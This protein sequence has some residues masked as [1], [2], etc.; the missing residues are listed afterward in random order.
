MAR[1]SDTSAVLGNEDQRRAAIVRKLA[2]ENKDLNIG[3]GT[4][5]DRA[6]PAASAFAQP[7]LASRANKDLNIGA[8]GS[9]P[10]QVQQD[11]LRQ[12][13]AA[14]AANERRNPGSTT[15][16]R[17]ADP[18]P[19][20][21]E[22]YG[23][24]NE[25]ALSQIAL[26]Q[27][28]AG[29]RAGSE[30]L[31]R[32]Q[33]ASE[34]SLRQLQGRSPLQRAVQSADQPSEQEA[35]ERG[36]LIGSALLPGPGILTKIPGVTPLLERAAAPITERA[37]PFLGSATKPIRE[38]IESRL[39][40]GGEDAFKNATRIGNENA[41]RLGESLPV[42]DLTKTRV[43][44]YLENARREAANLQRLQ[45]AERSLG[46]VDTPPTT[47][48]RQAILNRLGQLGSKVVQ[49]PGVRAVNPATAGIGL[50]A[51]GAA[52]LA[53][54]GGQASE[55]VPHGNAPEDQ[56]SLLP[57]GQTAPA[58][59][60]PSRVQLPQP[61]P[62]PITTTRPPTGQPLAVPRPTGP[63]TPGSQQQP[64]SQQQPLDQQ[65][66]LPPL[67][68]Q[69][70]PPPPSPG[71]LPPL[72]QLPF[73]QIP[74][75]AGPGV[76]LPQLSDLQQAIIGDLNG[77]VQ[78]INAG[79]Q[80]PDVMAL[81][82]SQAEKI[83]GLI[84][85]QEKQL[86]ADAANAGQSVDPATQNMIDQLKEALGEQ[87]KKTREAL[88]SRGLLNSGILIE[89]EQMLRKGNLSDQARIM[90]ERLSR[91][92][93]NL[94]A[95]LGTLRQQRVSTAQQYG[96]AGL[97]AQTQ[98]DQAERQRLQE[99]RGQVLQGRLGL[100][101]Q[102]GQQYEAQQNRGLQVY[103]QQIDQQFKSDQAA[104]NR[105]F[106]EAQQNAALAAQAGNARAERAW[107]E[108]QNEIQRQWDA[109][110]NE[111][112][113]ASQYAVAQ[114]NAATR[115]NTR[116][117][118]SRGYDTGATNEA[119]RRLQSAAAGGV[120]RADAEAELAE[121]GPDLSMQGVDLNRLRTALDQI[122]GSR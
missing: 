38:L 46:I 40:R 50:A 39:G 68:Q 2:R 88:A 62:A 3:S 95:Q 80:T 87:L 27:H 61:T 109:R 29:E 90:A 82:A 5:V 65:P 110:Q 118:A 92:Q 4:T 45:E 34:M 17:T 51:A 47:P 12:I 10:D 15:G 115:E 105:A 19:Y 16:G 42:R 23:A 11:I 101:Q 26:E 44:S 58:T 14:N 114:L 53:Q 49:A 70:P 41:A 76:G 48:Y 79:P 52:G 1:I 83:L 28:R 96:M 22:R 77:L 85:E 56:Y 9:A 66:P 99:L 59:V 30:D 35:Q 69:P 31:R 112:Q 64:P 25:T 94:T 103:L 111:L 33:V 113:R 97:Q 121:F 32:G 8:Q 6:T 116:S 73:Q 91:I 74:T 119:I 54:R 20:T 100:S 93:D 18:N 107:K 120:S 102:V 86:R 24:S 67:V 106:E 21:S 98:A 72:G 78:Q 63:Q 71:Q 104:A 13:A 122:Y 37:L 75:F 108:R 84:A 57:P 117:P 36:L 7:T 43:P 81:Y 55:Q 89:A 60:P